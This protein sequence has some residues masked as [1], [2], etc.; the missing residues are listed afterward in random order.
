MIEKKTLKQVIDSSLREAGFFQKGQS[1]Y[2]SS[3]DT[4]IVINLQKSSWDEQYYL[5]IGFW[6]NALGEATY[7]QHNRCHLYYRAEN[8]FQDQKELILTS[9]SLTK[10]NQNLL[11]ELA[12]FITNQLTPFLLECRSEKKLKELMSQGVLEGGFVK[13]E[14]R[15]HL[16]E[17]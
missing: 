13:L 7:P 12:L 3:S 1:W 16:L 17:N 15:W 11:N 2:L 14:A 10:S 4:I 9:C 5:N 8:F 6:L